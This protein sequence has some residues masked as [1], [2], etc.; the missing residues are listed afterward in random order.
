MV[1]LQAPLLHCW[2]WLLQNLNFTLQSLGDMSLYHTARCYHHVTPYVRLICYPTS[3]RL[4]GLTCQHGVL[5]TM[6]TCN[7]KLPVGNG[8]TLVS[9]QGAAY[10][11]LSCWSA[12]PAGEPLA[13][14][15]GVNS[16]TSSKQATPGRDNSSG[17]HACSL[18]I[19]P[20]LRLLT[21]CQRMDLT[22]HC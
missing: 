2:S 9:Q 5:Q 18:L 21:A 16:R 1:R 3:V 22:A 20:P 8:N 7:G 17:Q 15:N 14:A 10:V 6:A 4:I 19:K 12:R 11:C 13:P